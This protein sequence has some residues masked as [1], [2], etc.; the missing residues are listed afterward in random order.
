MKKS[1]N[2]RPP[3]AEASKP[4]PAK[5]AMD[6]PSGEASKPFEFNADI[7][8]KI[9]F[10]SLI[11][12]LLLTW[13][14]GF[15]VGYHQDEMDMNKNGM[16]N[17][18]F[19]KSGG[20][21]TGY[22]RNDTGF[23]ADTLLRYYGNAF[24]YIAV[25]TNKLTGNIDK[26][27]E[28]NVRHIYNQLF[29]I[30]AILFSGLIAKRFG[31]WLTANATIWLLYFSPSFEGHFL[32]NTK[33]V[34]FCAGYIACLYFIIKFIDTLPTPS[35]KT[36]IG[37]MLSFAF[38]NSI[39]LGGFLLAAYFVLFILIAMLNRDNLIAGLKNNITD[40]LVKTGV[41]FGGAAAIILISWPY[42]LMNPL[43][44]V[45]EG[46]DI[47]KKFPIKIPVNFEGVTLSSKDLPANYIPKLMLLTTPML[48]L[49]LFIVGV[50]LYFSKIKKASWQLGGIILVASF[51]P[52]AYTIINKI[53]L[54][55]GWRHL[56][57]IYPG[58]VIFAAY[59]LNGLVNKLKKPSLI[60][61]V[62]A[63]CALGIAKPVIWSFNNHPYEY[64]YFNEIAGG[65]K[66]TFYTYDNDYWQIT[67]VRAADW[68]IK[69]EHLDHTKDTI[70][71]GS[72][73]ET[74]AANYVKTH[75]PGSKVKFIKSGL[76]GRN[77]LYWT[78]GLYS[79][80]FIKP[81][82]LENYF[83]PGPTIYSVKIDDIPI[84]VVL[85]D[86]ARLDYLALDALKAAKH[87]LADSLY[88]LHIKNMHDDNPALL[89]Y[90]SVVKGSINENEDAISFANKALSYHFS[91]VLDYNA[92]CGLGVA[93]A[94]KGEYNLSI[95]NLKTAEKLLP[96]EHYSKDILAQVYQAMKM[97]K[98][99]PA[100][101]K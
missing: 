12:M 95:Q 70:I 22:L 19:Y 99:A 16:V 50:I 91:S 92:Y 21:D 54:Y 64:T 59:G 74:V 29:G 77:S 9:F 2:K 71:I 11:F 35:W 49:A 56:L 66:N 62:L 38:T 20:K 28:Y 87:Q 39:R 86:T 60:I 75:Y 25:G 82:Y 18:V 33:D 63:I 31:G 83:P 43:K 90:Y 5:P 45:Q 65:F 15:D 80:L 27:N 41:A 24:E 76:T 79:S 93:Y 13:F 17:M 58:I 101:Q 51:L 3:V 100:P 81:D 94:N 61:A 97:P 84:T 47:A 55:N 53:N 26:K 69:H 7:M 42:M 10:F 1:D 88:K 48:I 37:L 32:F 30:I 98:A 67:T 14:T 72:N 85:K 34:P 23:P 8:K 46:L 36:T 44:H 40:F 78:Y 96:A 68:L 52:V 57:F 73:A 6:P 89:A 4:A